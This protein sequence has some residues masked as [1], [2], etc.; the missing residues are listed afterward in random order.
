MRTAI[1]YTR[2]STDEQADRGY[3]LLDQKDRLE[4]YCELKGIEVLVHF[5][6][7]YSAKNF[8]RPGFVDLLQYMKANKKHI[9][10]LLF[11]NWS[12]FSRN[13]NDSYAM[14]DKLNR[15]GIVPQAID[16]PLDMEVPE[17]KLMLAFYLASP[18]V[19]NHRRSLNVIKGMR[20]AQK[21]GR[22]LGIAPF[23]YHNRKDEK[24]RPILVPDENAALL[25]QKVF[26]EVAKGIGTRES[27]REKYFYKGLVL[28]KSQFYRM[29][30]NPVYIGKVIVK[31]Y[32]DESEEWAEGIHTPILNESLF[33][34]VQELIK[35][36]QQTNNRPK[37]NKL[38]DALPLRGFLI[39]PKCGRHLTGSS[40]KGNGG[41]YTYYHCQKKLGCSERQKAEQV[42]EAF[43]D[44]LNELCIKPE[45]KELYN[46]VLK[47]SLSESRKSGKKK[48][49]ELQQKIDKLS[50][51]LERLQDMLA[52]G[53][54]DSGEFNL[55]KSRYQKELLKMKAEK[56]EMLGVDSSF[57]KELD[58]GLNL[59]ESLPDLYETANTENK[60]KIVGS[61]FKGTFI[62]E[63]EAY[64]TIEL[65]EVVKLISLKTNGLEIRK[66]ELQGTLLED[67]GLVVRRGIEP[68]LPG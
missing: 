24:E 22:Y 11:V 45:V 41:R 12:R 68:L 29:L 46:L 53:E 28:Q 16:Q 63:N 55:I 18:E 39:C 32:K 6:D 15:V 50:G 27:I 60:Q 19:D 5:T 59:L 64:R 21:M 10:G 56:R 2:V 66:P 23:G 25:V 14:I 57:E 36:I 31:A 52:D 3:S 54:I 51:R 26:A 9:D 47:D 48:A 65:N 34:K 42:N 38:R 67:S 58:F 7:D 33:W 4:K 17:N 37:V 13:T 1:L 40:S 49:K 62:Y 44:V 20:R 61:I 30:H 43:Q 8:N 35:G